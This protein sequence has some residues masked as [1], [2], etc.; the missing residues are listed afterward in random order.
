[1]CYLKEEDPDHYPRNN[2]SASSSYADS[3]LY[4]QQQQMHQHRAGPTQSTSSHSY[5]SMPSSSSYTSGLSSGLSSVH[6]PPPPGVTG[7]VTG[8]SGGSIPGTP[9][10]VSTSTLGRQQVSPQAQMLVA[11]LQEAAGTLKKNPPY[12][13]QSKPP[14]VSTYLSHSE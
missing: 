1:M 13:P 10:R 5:L 9:R 2:M 6:T 8:I 7:H 4:Q 3:F 14:K 12:Y 11:E